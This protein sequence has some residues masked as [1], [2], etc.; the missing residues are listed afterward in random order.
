MHSALAESDDA[1][2]NEML[3]VG[4]VAPTLHAAL[5]DEVRRGRNEGDSMVEL[6]LEELEQQQRAVED[7][8]VEVQHLLLVAGAQRHDVA[9]ISRGA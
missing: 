2:L 6:M 1:P 4:S 9:A 8:P 7:G 3:R 5:S